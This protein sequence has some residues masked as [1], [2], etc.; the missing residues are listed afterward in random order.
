MKSEKILYTS[1]DVRKAI[2]EIFGASKGR[3]VAITAFVGSGAEAYLPNPKGIE[4]ICWPKAGG[5]NPN[6]IRNLIKRGVNVSFANA[7]HMKIYWTEDKG[8]V[9]TSANLST[10]ALGSGG[11]REIGILV[12]SKFI[13]ISLILND[14]SPKSDI[15]KKLAELDKAHQQYYLDNKIQPRKAKS[16]TYL[17]W[18]SSSSQIRSKWKLGYCDG[19]GDFSQN[20]IKIAKN[21][22]E[23]KAP[24]LFI[25]CSKGNY[26]EGEWVLTFHVNGFRPIN[27]DWLFVD[28]IAPTAKKDKQYDKDNPFQAVQVWPKDRYDPPFK[29]DNKFRSA[30]MAAIKDKKGADNLPL[31]FT[32]NLADLVKKHYSKET[33]SDIGNSS[34]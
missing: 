26:S 31:K 27:F 7:L 32:E 17:D 34:T 25:G 19:Y 16:K 14:I 12:P 33:L 2:I 11:L 4:L 9:I 29:I 3:R 13:D 28:Y 24:Q 6:E 22:Y 20:A 30:L 5:T 21:D 18:Y 10:N 1:S 23:V 8:A 15:K